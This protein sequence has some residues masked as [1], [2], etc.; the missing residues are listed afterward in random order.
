MTYTMGI[1]V[2]TYSSKGVIV[3]E[4]GVIVAQAETPH[5]LAVPRV[6]WAEHDAEAVWWGDFVKVCRDLLEQARTTKDIDPKQIVGVGTSAI[7]PCVLPVDDDGRPLRP[8]ILYGID[9]RASEEIEELTEKLGD[10]WL[11]EHIGTEL[12]SQSAGPKILWLQR[13]EPQVWRRTWK[14]MTSTSYLVFRL[15]GRVV[16]DHYTAA[17][18]H[19]LYD[20][21]EQSWCS[22]GLRPICDERTLPETEWAAGV[23]GKVTSEAAQ[24]TGLAEG[25]PVIA[26]TADAAS[27]AVSAGAVSIGD[28][29]LMY[30]S[31]LFIISVCDQLRTGG[32]FWPAPFLVPG[33]YAI[34]A[35]MSTAGS[36]S[37]WFRDTLADREREAA[38]DEGKSAYQALSE[39]AADIPPGSDGLV[40]LPYFSGER[41][42]I[43][44][45]AARGMFAGLNLRTTKGHLYRSILEGVGYG[46]RHNLEEME[47]AG[48]SIETLKGVGGGTKSRLW[49][50]IV[51]DIL[52]RD[53]YIRDTPGASFGDAALA[54]LGTGTVPDLSSIDGWVSPAQRLE[55]D[56]D[57]F[58]I[59]SRYYDLYRRFYESTAEVMHDLVRISSS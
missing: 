3:D 56:K 40:L 47:R 48:H 4:R 49:V 9:T 53:Q 21:H 14:I 27:E 30:G 58:E 44:D 46:I 1:D 13:N 29:M 33:V 39:L 5:D 41:T 25:T 34:A 31:S 22:E 51:C 54:A 50:Q 11:S 43:N 16:I 57:R 15:T 10:D 36:L 26:G 32:V 19:P 18:Y 7:G 12:S 17:S 24:E 20:I 23:A 42:P 6:G 38:E 28:T 45:P 8:A 52:G 35:G 2:G 37:Q 59:Y 55:A